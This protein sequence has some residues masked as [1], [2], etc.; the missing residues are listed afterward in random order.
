LKAK[1]EG[2]P[3]DQ[4]DADLERILTEL[5]RVSSQIRAKS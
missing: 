3:P 5:A 4:Y 1:K 2:M